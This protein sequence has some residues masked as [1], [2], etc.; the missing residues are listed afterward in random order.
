MPWKKNLQWWTGAAIVVLTLS[1]VAFAF[2]ARKPLCIDSKLVEKIDIISERG[3]ATAFRCGQHRHVPYDENLAKLTKRSGQRLQSLERFLDWLGPL[4]FQ[5]HMT[6]IVGSSEVFRIQDHHVHIGEKILQANGQL[7]KT[8]LRVWFRERAAE[9]LRSEPLVEEALTDLLY[10]AYVGQM[11]L[12]DPQ[13]GL[14]YDQDLDPRWPRVLNNW[15][16]Y[17]QGLWKSHE[18]LKVCS[19][20]TG[21]QN[22]SILPRSLRPLLSTALIQSFIQLRAAEQ[23]DLIHSLAHQLSQLN[24][25]DKNFGLSHFEPDKQRY[26]EAI[27]QL[28]NW[29]YFVSNVKVAQAEKFATHFRFELEKRGFDNSSRQ[30]LLDHL[31]FADQLNSEQVAGLFKEIEKR[32]HSLT[33]IETHGTL[34]MNAGSEPLSLKLLGTVKATTGVYFHCGYPTSH[35]L[36]AL[37]ERVERLLYVNVCHNEPI[38]LQGFLDRGVLSFA[39]QNPGLKFAE[40]HLPSLMMALKRIPGKNPVYLLSLKKDESLRPI[41]WKEPLFDEA[42][43][44]YRAQSAIEMVQWYRL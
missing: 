25:Q 30:A 34:K 11:D 23:L 19:N 4:K 41:G 44:A 33:G 2:V 22:E 28:E 27:S 42:V 21:F 10:F 3:I 20:L 14:I 43:N 8:I 7:E 16:G 26:Y 31:I 36:A 24:F 12:Q 6:V 38:Y 35:K 17:C 1:L 15:R 9:S 39:R 40:F 37:A 5:I 18:D 13:S 32:P 29:I